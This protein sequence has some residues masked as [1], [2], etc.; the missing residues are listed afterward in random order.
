M[1][2]VEKTKHFEKWFNDLKDKKLKVAVRRK[3]ERMEKEEH[4]W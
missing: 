1:L 2:K 3:I 4:I